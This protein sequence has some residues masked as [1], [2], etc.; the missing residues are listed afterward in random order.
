[1]HIVLTGGGTGGHVVPNLAIAEAI[2]VLT[3]G[4]ASNGGAKL[5]YI[6]SRHG[7]ERKLAK[8][9][10]ISFES[11]PVGKLRRYFDLRN[12]AD[13]FRV[14]LGIFQAWLKLGRLKPDLVFSKGGFVGFPVVF[15][16]YL[17]GIPA[18]THE[19]DSIPG[20][21]TKLSAR[22]AKKVFL[23]YEEAATELRK[24]KEKLEF[25]G[26]PVRDEIFKGSAARAKKLTGFSGKK[27]VLLVM[28]G[29]GGSQQINE[30]V[31]MEKARLMEIFDLIH[32]T[33]EGKGGS[34][35]TEAYFPVTYVHEELKD[36]YALA[37]LALSRAGAN[38]IAELEALQIPTLLY[39]L[40]RY[41][42]RGD[43]MANAQAISMK[44]KLFTISDE[45]KN[46]HSQLLL[47]PK[48][49]KSPRKNDVAKNDVAKNI[50]TLLL[51]FAG[52]QTSTGQ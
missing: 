45:K 9:A 40:G 2:R 6:G 44:S 34:R 1:M 51:N 17:R 4:G 38:S 13:A 52:S 41:A 23:G 30:I 15:A 16:A 37:S 50:A 12:F 21:A 29:S 25:V 22:F 20:L 49:K 35:K 3:N 32:I 19:S 10:G 18:I 42:S 5:S 31:G 14:P 33:G 26:N 27:P 8:K 48:R 7:V 28:G 39:P 43:Q 46:A 11:I 36:F 47:L 24:F